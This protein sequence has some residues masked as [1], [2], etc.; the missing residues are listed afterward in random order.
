MK[1]KIFIT[2]ISLILSITLITGASAFAGSEKIKARMMN[3]PPVIRALKAEGIIGEN[4]K[5]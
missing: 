4:N 3:R 1:T 2:I 5:G